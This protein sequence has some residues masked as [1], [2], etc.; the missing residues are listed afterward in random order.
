MTMSH[1][2]FVNEN[3][4][5]EIQLKIQQSKE[6]TILRAWLLLKAQW[7]FKKNNHPQEI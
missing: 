3:F 5:N 4:E 1:F 2:F 6:N 7:M